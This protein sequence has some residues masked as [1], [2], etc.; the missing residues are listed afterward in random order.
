MDRVNEGHAAVS[1]VSLVL[2]ITWSGSCSRLSQSGIGHRVDRVSEGHA[3]VSISLVLDT[4][5]TGSC[6]RL[7]QSGIGHKADRVTLPSLS[8]WYIDVR[9]TVAAVVSIQNTANNSF[10]TIVL[11]G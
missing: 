1:L 3:A 6:R 5:W 10:E 7:Y 9:R 4:G 8:A 11:R 2:N